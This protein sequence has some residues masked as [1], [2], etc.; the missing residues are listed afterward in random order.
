[1]HHKPWFP[2]ICAIFAIVI[3]EIIA[4]SNSINGAGLAVAITVI[5]TVG[6]YKAGQYKERNKAKDE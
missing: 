6:G 1:M 2:S 3:L 4:L 5:A